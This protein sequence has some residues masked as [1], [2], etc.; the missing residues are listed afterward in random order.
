MP[1]IPKLLRSLLA[2][3]VIAATGCEIRDQADESESA[4]NLGNAAAA[5]SN[6]DQGGPAG[7]ITFIEGFERGMQVARDQQRPLLLY[8]TAQ[9]CKYCHQMEREAFVQQAVIDRSRDFVCVLIDADAEPAACR[10]FE[11][12]GFP[13]IQFVSARGLRLN[14]VT[15]KQPAGQLLMQMRAALQAVARREPATRQR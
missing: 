2:T 4:G 13:T 1:T 12:R 3:L 8:F 6:R 9:W 5:L 7:Q 10:Q 14:R 11:V 15:G